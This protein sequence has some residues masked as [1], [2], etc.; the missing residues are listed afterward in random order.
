MTARCLPDEVD[1]FRD[2]LDEARRYYCNIVGKYGTQVTALLTKAAGLELKLVCPL[3]GFVWRRNI[4]DFVEKY[5]NWATYTP[6]EQGVV[7]AYASVYGNTA[8]AAGDPGLPPAGEGREGVHVR[9][10]H[11]AGI[12]HH[13]RSVPL[14]PS[15]LCFHYL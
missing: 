13:R 10:V 4:G 9:R 5:L 3:H 11:D 1:F 8:N 6:E 2:Y 7:L 14:Q 15:G 12:P